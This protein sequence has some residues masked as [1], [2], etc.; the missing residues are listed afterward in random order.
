MR[1]IEAMGFVCS[2]PEVYVVPSPKY[3]KEIVDKYTPI[4][5]RFTHAVTFSPASEI[6]SDSTIFYPNDKSVRIS[7]LKSSSLYSAQNVEEDKWAA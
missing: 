2:T 7:L 4:P 3:K 5:R 1:E 6:K